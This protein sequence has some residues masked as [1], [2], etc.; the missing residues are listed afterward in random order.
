MQEFYRENDFSSFGF[1]KI[2]WKG[3]LA[4][5]FILAIF[6]VGMSLILPPKNFPSGEVV[7]IKKGDSL[8][9]IGKE[10]KDKKI[11]KSSG[12]FKTFVI[13][14]G[15]EKVISAGDY[16][17]KDP[18]NA[19]E[20]ARRVAGSKF[21]VEKVSVT[22]PEGLSTKEMAKVLDGR[23]ANFNEEEFLFWTKDLE[24]KLFPDTY[25]FFA[26]AKTGEIVKLLNDTFNKKVDSTIR[27]DIEKSGHTFDEIIIMASIIQDE[28][29]DNY[30]EKQIISGILWK[31]IKKGM[32]L[33][34]D[35]TLRYVNG[36]ESKKLTVE[37]LAEDN[38]YNTY[39][40]YGLPPTPI[41]NPGLDAIRAAV[42][43]KDSP[44]LFYL[45]DSDG[46]VHYAKTFEE[47]KKNIATYLR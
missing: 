27:T 8:T 44:Y 32:K 26:T 22:L 38:P 37:D 39:V 34:T 20:V 5:I 3:I 16:V 30:E 4:V 10:F 24:G 21:G 6:F 35:A 33:Q 45:H 36:K 31:R 9:S 1:R 41:G 29:F 13:A 2:N 14:F 46:K 47:H 12:L 17:F 7:T 23:L 42:Y 15:G 11:V 40:H 43:P 28:A 18:I 19:V 25:F